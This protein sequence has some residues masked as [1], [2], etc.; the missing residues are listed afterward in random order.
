MEF[1]VFQGTAQSGHGGVGGV[2]ELQRCDGDS[3]VADG[4]VVTTVLGILQRD[5]LVHPVVGAVH[6]IAGLDHV[7]A[8]N[9][10]ALPGDRNSGRFPDRNIDVQDDAGRQ[11]VRKDPRGQPRSNPGRGL[12]V[13]G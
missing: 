4:G 1:K 12:V 3:T 11:A 8:G 10:A 13:D 7:V 9:L 6:R 5:I 2:V